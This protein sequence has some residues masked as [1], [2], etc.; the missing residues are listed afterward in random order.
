[1]STAKGQGWWLD[2]IGRVPLL[3]PAEEIELGT[4]IQAWLQHPDGVEDCPRGIRRRGERARRRFIEANLRLAVSYVSKHCFRLCKAENHDDL[5][6]A[7]NIGV[8]R[9]VEKFDPQRGYRF[10]TYAYWWIRQSVNRWIDLYSRTIAIPGSHSQLLA[11]VEGI[12]R[13]LTI[14]LGQMPGRDDLAEAVGISGEQLDAIL[15][16]AQLP[17]SLDRGADDDEKSDLADFLGDLDLDPA[18]EE[19]QQEQVTLA[20]ELLAAITPQ[21]RRVVEA[22]FGIG[23]PAARMAEIAQREGLKARQAHALYRSALAAMERSRHQRHELQPQVVA[24]QCDQLAL[25]TD[26]SEAPA[27]CRG[28]VH[29]QVRGRSRRV[30]TPAQQLELHVA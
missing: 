24:E 21:Q 23:Q 14:E 9:A 10:S 2:Q 20:G 5:V 17:L 4:A 25:I 11:K 19:T 6:Q 27:P 16:R 12:R 30:C 22:A 28:I 15:M 29:R 1:M 8:M 3:T 26:P 7:A 13:R 18:E